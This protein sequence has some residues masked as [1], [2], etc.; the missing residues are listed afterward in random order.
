[1]WLAKNAVGCIIDTEP[2]WQN[3]NPD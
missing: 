2:G 3:G 1:L